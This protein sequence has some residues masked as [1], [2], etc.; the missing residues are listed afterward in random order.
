[1]APADRP[2]RGSCD[3]RVVRAGGQPGRCDVRG[4]VRGGGRPGT[5]TRPGFPPGFDSLR[6][7]VGGRLA[8]PAWPRPHP[9]PEPSSLGASGNRRRKRGCTVSQ[10]EGE[11]SGTHDVNARRRRAPDEP[12]E[13]GE[14]AQVRAAASFFRAG[15]TPK[16]LPARAH[17]T[18]STVSSKRVAKGEPS[19]PGTP[20]TRAGPPQQAITA[21]SP[22]PSRAGF[23]RSPRPARRAGVVG[24]EVAP[25]RPDTRR[26]AADAALRRHVAD[27]RSWLQAQVTAGRRVLG[28]STRRCRA[29]RQPGRGSKPQNSWSRKVG[30]P[31]KL[32]SS[33]VG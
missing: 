32:R 19:V 31:K 3:G 21:A 27:E 30:V 11:L 10:V 7:R 9:S 1:M 8:G 28:T 17:S 13:G 12:D 2:R 22:L 26:Y 15:E 14:Q 4:K 6:W 29:G 20:W 24:G 23:E 5:S 25:G 33:E 18:C 16:V